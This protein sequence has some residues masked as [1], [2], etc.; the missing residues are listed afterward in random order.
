MLSLSVRVIPRDIQ[1]RMH[2][3]SSRIWKLHYLVV[4]LTVLPARLG[5][6]ATPRCIVCMFGVWLCF[7]LHCPLMLYI[8]FKYCH[9]GGCSVIVCPH[10][11]SHAC[12]VILHLGGCCCCFSSVKDQKVAAIEC[13]KNVVTFFYPHILC[14]S[15]IV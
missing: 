3:C 1:S 9:I 5:P 13:F 15:G 14:S 10:I 7:F 12:L 4:R 2:E 6:S 11:P 8:F